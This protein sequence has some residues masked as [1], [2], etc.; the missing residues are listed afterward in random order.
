MKA[1]KFLKKIRTWCCEKNC[2][3]G[4]CPMAI[5]KVNS[6]GEHYTLCMLSMEEPTDWNIDN[7]VKAVKKL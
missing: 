4:K 7:M 3:Y 2:W 1:K 5:R 6:K